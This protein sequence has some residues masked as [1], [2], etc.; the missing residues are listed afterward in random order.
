MVLYLLFFVTASGVVV[1]AVDPGD[2]RRHAPAA[3]RPQDADHQPRGDHALDRLRRRR[4]SSPPSSRSSPG[5]TPPDT[6]VPTA[7]LTMTFVVMGLGTV[8]NALTN[9]R[10][11]PAGSSPPLL[12]R[13]AISLVPTG[14]DRPGHP[15][16]QPAEGPS[17]HVPRPLSEWLACYLSRRCCCRS[18]SKPAS[19]SAGAGARTR[20]VNVHERSPPSEPSQ[21]T[22]SKNRRNKRHGDDRTKMRE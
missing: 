12:K 14:D 11:R 13:S 8:F 5:R 21:S 22:S 15:A 10:T 9:R 20:Q 4:S 18:W 2:A 19:G 17:H 6:H 3:P 1:I 16:A 7:S